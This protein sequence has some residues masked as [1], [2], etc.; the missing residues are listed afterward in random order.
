M[1]VRKRYWG[2]ELDTESFWL[3]VVLQIRARSFGNQPI[4]KKWVSERNK[5]P[6][7]GR[8]MCERG[9]EEFRVR[10]LS[11]WSKRQTWAWLEEINWMKHL[12]SIEDLLFPLQSA[13]K[14]IRAGKTWIS[15]TSEYRN[16][17]VSYQKNSNSDEDAHHHRGIIGKGICDEQRTTL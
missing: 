4:R 11:T 10:S 17:H 15:F 1:F 7:E 12:S 13:L 14:F 8:M 16:V 5:K 9:Q 2:G 6:K 3:R